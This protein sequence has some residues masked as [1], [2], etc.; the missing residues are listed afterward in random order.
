MGSLMTNS[1]LSGLLTA[2]WESLSSLRD[3]VTEQTSETNKRLHAIEMQLLQGRHRM[4][5][6]ERRQRQKT[7]GTGMGWKVFMKEVAT[8]REWLAGATLIVLAL[9]GALEPA[10]FKAMLLTFIGS[11]PP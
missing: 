3:H 2:I 4:T 7:N 10:E 1:D 8:F 9:K 11:G 6:I 5:D